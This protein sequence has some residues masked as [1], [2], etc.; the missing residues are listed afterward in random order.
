MSRS[1]EAVSYKADNGRNV[2]LTH[3]ADEQRVDWNCGSR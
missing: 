2:T 1:S 3:I